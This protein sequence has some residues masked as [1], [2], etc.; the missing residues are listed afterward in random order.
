MSRILSEPVRA[1]CIGHADTSY[2]ER[3]WA[4]EAARVTGA[5]Y[6]DEEIQPQG[7][8]LLPALVRHF[9]EPFGDSSAIPTWYVSR[10]A[11]RH[12]KMVLSGDGGDELFAGY[13]A[14][15]AILCAHR[16]PRSLAKRLRHLIANGARRAGFWPQIATVADNKYARTGV[17]Q[18]A[19]RLSLWRPEHNNIVIETRQQFDRRLSDVSGGELLNDLQSF[20]I[21]NYVPFDNLTKVDIASMYHGLEVRVPLLDHVFMETVAQIPPEL[22]LKPNVGNGTGRLET[23]ANSAAVTG[24]YLL[25]KNAERFFSHEFLHREKRGFEVPIRNW[26]AGPHR[27][28]LH[29]RLLGEGTLLTEY[30]Q[31]DAISELVS[32]AGENKVA[33]WKSWSLLVLDEWMRQQSA[34]TP[35]AC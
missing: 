18:A 5:Q 32:L 29:S 6:F 25:K 19:E 8:D 1:F 34:D 9:G 27:E 11:R 7:L 21:E 33:A 15:S 24:K 4:T 30:F 13:H 20:D 3:K 17:L 26:F 2:D 31:P 14:Y 12:V 28:E 35:M 10:L 23:L 16:R 22:K